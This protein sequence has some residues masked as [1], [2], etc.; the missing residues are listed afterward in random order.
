VTGIHPTIAPEERIL[1]RAFFEVDPLDCADA[2]IGTT[3]IWGRCSGVVVETEDDV[4]V[5]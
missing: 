4:T 5:I 1:R 2:L 3:L